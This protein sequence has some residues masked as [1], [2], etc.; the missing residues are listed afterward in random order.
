METI[1][2]LC[3]YFMQSTSENPDLKLKIFCEIGEGKVIRDGRRVLRKMQQTGAFCKKFEKNC[4]GHMI[5]WK[6]VDHCVI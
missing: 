1:E 5:G 6:I 2:S 4:I 3:V